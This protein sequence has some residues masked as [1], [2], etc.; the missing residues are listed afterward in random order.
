[1]TNS[2]TVVV[3]DLLVVEERTPDLSFDVLDV[4]LDDVLEWRDLLERRA[5]LLVNVGDSLVDKASPQSL[6]FAHSAR[7]LLPN[8]DDELEDDPPPEDDEEEF[9]PCPPE[10]GD[11]D[12]ELPPL[13]DDDELPPPLEDEED[14]EEPPPLLEDE[15]DEEPPLPPDEDEDEDEDPLLPPLLLLDDEEEAPPEPLELLEDDG[16]PEIAPQAPSFE[17]ELELPVLEIPGAFPLSHT[18]FS[19]GMSVLDIGLASDELSTH[20]RLS[21]AEAGCCTSQTT[22][23]LAWLTWGLVEEG[24]ELAESLD[25]VAVVKG[26]QAESAVP[27]ASEFVGTLSTAGRLEDSIDE[28]AAVWS[29]VLT[30]LQISRES[31][32]AKEAVGVSSP[33]PIETLT[34]GSGPVAHMP[35]DDPV[36]I[37]LYMEVVG[38]PDPDETIE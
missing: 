32:L 5:F 25:V 29:I 22:E 28:V 35:S 16:D 2:S 30:V 23:G 19:F 27:L 8:D 10:D 9:P 33:D 18:A 24:I 21:S 12:D 13:E 38:D 7:K 37:V 6:G 34:V 26:G 17:V 14:D 15:E 3:S 36:A 1:M 20:C 11:D 4:E 31:S